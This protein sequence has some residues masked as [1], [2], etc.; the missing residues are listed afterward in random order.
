MKSTTG[1]SRRPGEARKVAIN[2]KSKVARKPAPKIARKPAPKV[3][4]KPAPKVVTKPAPKVAKTPSSARKETA[5]LKAPKRPQDDRGSKIILPGPPDETSRQEEEIRQETAPSKVTVDW[6]PA[7][8]DHTPQELDLII[9]KLRGGG[10]HDLKLARF[11]T[12]IRFSTRRLPG[13]RPAG[14]D[15]SRRVGTP[16]FFTIPSGFW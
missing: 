6:G 3:A 12:T 8:H 1:K 9:R 13:S 2:A 5:R 7:S 16:V 15:I 14:A 4:R 10:P 11:G